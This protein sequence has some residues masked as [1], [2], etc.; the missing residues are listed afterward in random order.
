[1][2][3]DGRPPDGSLWFLP[4]VERRCWEEMPGFLLPSAAER[5]YR[6]AAEAPPD[7]QLVELGTFAG[8][9]LVCLAAGVR[10]RPSSEGVMLTAVDLQF[11][12]AWSD[13]V[14]RFALGG[15]V[16]Q[17]EMSSLDAADAW[18]G[19]I[20]LLYIDAHHGPA[21]ARADL[22][23]WE[24]FV[25]AGGIVALDDT[26]GFYPGC[27]LAVQMAVASGS[28]ELLDDVGGVTFLRKRAPLFRGV[29]F[30]P[31][32]RETAFATLAAVSAW[33]GAMDPTL[34]LP[35]PVR[36][37][38]SPELID[39]RLHRALADLDEVRDATDDELLDELLPTLTYL[40]AL[41]RLR[42]GDPDSSLRLLDDLALDGE[43]TFVHYD[44]EIAPLVRLRQAQVHDL[45]GRRDDALRLYAAVLDD[46]AIEA[47]QVAAAE[48]VA[49]RFALPE[50]EPG[51]LLREYVLDSPL[52]PLR[53]PVAWPHAPG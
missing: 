22:V 40:E 47:V 51:R 24:P 44:L 25:V 10:S 45:C 28:F 43:E 12:P 27:T 11:H 46:G 38:L 50:P 23:A 21:H 14:D 8:K 5:L 37:A 35:N 17:L 39:E 1:M 16:T 15:L 52:G 9:S 32:Q 3:H 19:P 36:F 20:A 49:H 33:V 48:G 6:A 29:G 18:S 30:A 53:R 26:V 34:R 4:E 13:T 2:V 31:M 7:G 41:V 42:L